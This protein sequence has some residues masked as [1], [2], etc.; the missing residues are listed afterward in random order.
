MNGRGTNAVPAADAVP[1]SLQGFSIFLGE[2]PLVTGVDF[3][4]ARGSS[5]VVIGPTGVGKS[6]LLKSIA[7]LL[8]ARTFRLGGSMRVQGIEAY[9]QGRKTRHARWSEIMERGLVFVP[10]ESAQAMNPALTLEQNRRLLAPDS[11]ALMERRLEQYFGLDFGSFARLYPDEVSG[12]ELQRITLMILLSRQG[13]LVLL[14]EPT[15]NLDRNLR[16]RFIDF[17]NAELLPSRDNTVLMASHD[18]D[19][20]QALALDEAYGLQDAQLRHLAAIPRANGFQKPEAR[21]APAEGLALRDLSQSYF[22]RGIFGERSFRAFTGL[23]IEFGRSII[24]GITGPSG[25]GKSSMIKAILRLLDGTRGDILLDGED[26]VRLKPRERGRDPGA[27]RSFRRK[28]TVAQQDSR[29]AFFPDRRIRDSFRYIAELQGG[30]GSFDREELLA[31][32][33][34]VGLSSVHLDAHPRS[35]SSGEMKRIDIA[36]ALA[37]KPEVLLLDEPFA[38]IDFDTRAKVMRAI[39]DYMAENATILLVVTHE[40]FDLRYF[41]EK[42]YD[43][44]ELVG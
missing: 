39:S 13:D 28:M 35:L 2:R 19:F 23:S 21:K 32:L 5:S 40:D 26:L 22:K 42:S 8:P 34:Q 29:F 37:A 15:V 41:V 36:R 43:F 38:H 44:P 3:A 16:R 6:V 7:G 4:P 31:R 17:L 14:D 27:F 30:P 10:A 24:Y 33:E 20:I 11:R 9:V 18:L 1:V 12:G 25:C